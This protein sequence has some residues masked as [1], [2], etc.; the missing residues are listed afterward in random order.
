M[1]LHNLF[2]IYSY[3]TYYNFITDLTFVNYVLIIFKI[4][5]EIFMFY[6]WILVYYLR[7]LYL[8]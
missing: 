5:Y 1:T 3:F 2:N 8:R 6:A 4:T 7:N